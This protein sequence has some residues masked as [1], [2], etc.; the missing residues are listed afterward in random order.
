LALESGDRLGPYEIQAPLGAGGMGEV[1]RAKDTR[2]G[3]DVAIKV[4]PAA[5]AT[6]EAHRRRFELETRAVGALNHPNILAIYDLGDHDGAPYLV[7]ELLEGQTLRE[8]LEAATILAAR[9]V[10]DYAIQVAR[11]LAAAH[12]K[13]IFHRDLKPENLFV[14]RDGHVKILDFGLAKLAPEGAGDSES[15]TRTHHTQPGT[16]MGTVGYMSPEQVRGASVDHRSDI[17]SFGA[18]LYE[19]LTGERAFSQETAA[20]TMTAV[21][22]DEPPELTAGD[23]PAPPGLDRIVG[24]CLEKK[25]ED[26]FQSARDLAFQLEAVSTSSGSGP[27]VPAPARKAWK[28]PTTIAIVLAVLIAISGVVNLVETQS[29][30]ARGRQ[31]TRLGLVLPEQAPPDL[32]LYQSLAVSP[33]GTRLVYAGY[34]AGRR[35]L[36]MRPLD[37]FEAGPIAG[38]EGGYGPF[39]SSDGEWL[40]FYA[41]GKLKKVAAAG[42][43]PLTLTDEAWDAHGAVWA[44][45]GTIVFTGRILEG[46]SR[47]PAAGGPPEPLTSLE[48]D[49]GGLS[50]F[51]PQLLPGGESV[52]FTV[53]RGTESD[54]EV[55]SLDSGER[56]LLIEGGAY[57]SYVRPGRLVY[58]QPGGSTLMAVP[59]S[60]QRLEVTGPPRPVLEG[61][62]TQPLLGTPHLCFSRTGTLLFAPAD[63]ARRSLARV[64]A[65]GRERSLDLDRGRYA[66]VRLSPDGERLALSVQDEG[67]DVWLYD[68]QRGGRERLTPAE[69]GWGPVWSPDGSRLVYTSG[70]EG[71]FQLLSKP[72]TGN[73]VSEALV[74]SRNLLSPGSWAPDGRQLLYA[75]F[76]P[77]SR[78]DIWTL[79]MEGELE[80]RPFLQTPFDERAPVF[81]PDGRLVAYISN[82]TGGRDTFQRWEVYVRVFEDPATRV[83]V[84][85]AGGGHD[86]VWGRSG[87]ELFYREG[88]R[89][90]AVSMETQPTLSAGPPRL[91]FDGL[92]DV[93]APFDVAADGT[94]LVVREPV[95]PRAIH[96]NVVQRWFEV[97]KRQMAPA[98]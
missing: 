44:E 68:L 33:D 75:E 41:E 27:A 39:F 56:K 65:Q 81:S 78:W 22:R 24:H 28:R 34:Q 38:T 11:G 66:T 7:S 60:R 19:M 96:L 87:R 88:S 79:P 18:V 43:A 16:V 83:R 6:D 10:V 90:M 82:E 63:L 35:H 47:I 70:R 93:G 57:A 92:A 54:V 21:L 45:D 50:H 37:Q 42:G 40:G 77:G 76:H 72:A 13:G 30:L 61:I 62:L 9:K 32:G 15:A 1:Y 49:R 71:A 84:S 26:R 86:P 25:P 69:R 95:G 29:D 48:P 2:I 3:R 91:V 46:L 12:E 20:E 98:R 52:L 55:V 97:L 73:A 64:D 31:I 74:E 8:V 89:L 23:R 59:F 51:W 14:T 85:T 17:F 5:A 94:F 36:F 4:L 58:M 80:S 67:L 53:W